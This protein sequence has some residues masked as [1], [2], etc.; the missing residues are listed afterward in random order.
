MSLKNYDD[1]T[2]F[3]LLKDLLSVSIFSVSLFPEGFS[4]TKAVY[5]IDTCK[6]LLEKQNDE[7]ENLIVSLLLE[8]FARNVGSGENYGSGFPYDL[9]ERIETKIHGEISENLICDI[10]E[11]AFNISDHRLIEIQR[12]DERVYYFENLTDKRELIAYSTMA[13]LAY[14]AIAMKFETT[15]EIFKMKILCRVPSDS[16]TPVLDKGEN[17]EKFL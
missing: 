10:L 3:S 13:D 5:V 15:Y 14:R 9:M 8:S 6:P 2:N 17:I 16:W 1:K 7:I 4:D 12:D 11:W